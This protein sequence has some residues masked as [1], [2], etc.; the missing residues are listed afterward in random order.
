MFL[1]Q[2]SDTEAHFSRESCDREPREGVMNIH[3]AHAYL[4]DSIV[5]REA[6]PGVPYEL[7]PQ[8]AL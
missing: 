2:R 1:C 5:K 3:L 7:L 4:V 6:P 8:A